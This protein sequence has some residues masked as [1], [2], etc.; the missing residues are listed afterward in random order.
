M[1]FPPEANHGANAGLLEARKRLEKIK[2]ANPGLSYADLYI[3]ASYVAIEEMG[4]PKI[5]FR[6]GR[7][8]AP[9]GEWCTPDGRLPGA[10]MGTKPGTIAHIK[11]IFYRMGL[12]DQEIVALV[13]A[14]ALGRCHT[15]RSGYTGPWTRAPTTFS[16]EYFRLLIETK[17]VKKQWKGP[18]QYENVDG[19]DLMML[20]ADLALV[21][22]QDFKLWVETYAKDEKRFFT[23]FAKA[24]AK[25]TE[26][27]CKNLAYR[28]I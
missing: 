14:H 25:L 20:P 19:G 27:G 21:E 24:Y 5:P 6:P 11:E 15:D 9:S 2:A 12:S 28:P 7:T 17:W 1:R 4:G 13:G 10:D 8:D 18:L 16:N 22:D 3:L 23:D 26:L